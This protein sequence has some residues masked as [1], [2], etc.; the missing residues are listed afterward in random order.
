MSTVLYRNLG[1]TMLI[2]HVKPGHFLGIPDFPHIRGI[3]ERKS[4]LL[5]DVLKLDF[6]VLCQP[7]I[8][9]RS[10]RHRFVDQF[11]FPEKV[12]DTFCSRYQDHLSTQNMKVLSWPLKMQFF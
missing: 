4:I 12:D 11:C 3:L 9:C 6:R 10:G 5:V 8:Y 2:P 7:T 1:L